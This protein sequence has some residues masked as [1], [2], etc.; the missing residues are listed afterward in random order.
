[1]VV[2]ASPAAARLLDFSLP[3]DVTL[4]DAT[5]AAFYGAGSNEEVLKASRSNLLLCRPHQILLPVAKFT[6]RLLCLLPFPLPFP[7]HFRLPPAP[8]ANVHIP[9]LARVRSTAEP[10]A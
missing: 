2:P 10:I 8:L 3:L 5:V 9:S 6:E 7:P 4:L 1:M